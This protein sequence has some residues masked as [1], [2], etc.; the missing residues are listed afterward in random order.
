MIFELPL[1]EGK[2]TVL[3]DNGKIEVLRHGEPWRNETG[4]GFLNALLMSHIELEFELAEVKDGL[5][6]MQEQSGYDI[7]DD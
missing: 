6:L 2:Y 4:D 5:A 7:F 3:Y 1:E